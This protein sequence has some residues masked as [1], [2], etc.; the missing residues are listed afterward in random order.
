MAEFFASQLAEKSSGLEHNIVDM[1]RTQANREVLPVASR[2]E[3][4]IVFKRVTPF[5]KGGMVCTV[6]YLRS[7]KPVVSPAPKQHFLFQFARI[8]SRIRSGLAAKLGSLRAR[9]LFSRP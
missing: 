9:A 5:P 4:E 7:T 8:F 2:P 1:K 3:A 6:S